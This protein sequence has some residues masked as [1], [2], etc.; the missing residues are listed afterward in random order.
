MN[1]EP[2]IAI[3][4]QAGLFQ[5]IASKSNGLILKSHLDG[6]SKFYS[7]RKNQFTSLGT[8]AVY[9][10]D[11]TTPLS[12]VFA[13]M[14]DKHTSNPPVSTKSEKH[15]I[16]EYFELIL[17]EYDEDK[18]PIRD[19]KKIIKWYSFLYERNLLS[20]NKDKTEEE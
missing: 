13:S 7:I 4:G 19:M 14:Y 16:E 12:E 3:T 11:G 10:L 2:Y 20:S 8:V 18:V 6:K 15:V 17:P 1:L 5:L 9:T